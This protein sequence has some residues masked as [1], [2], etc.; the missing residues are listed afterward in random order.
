MLAHPRPSRWAVAGLLVLT[1]TA[2]S[3]RAEIIIDL[4]A[5]GASGSSQGA[6]FFQVNP[7]PTGTGFVDPFV[8][9]QRTGTERGYNTEGQI[10]FDTKDQGGHNWTHA[11]A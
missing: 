1:A 4:T 5:Y 2:S 7:Q 6:H 9:I 3:A 11:L 10:E 8:R